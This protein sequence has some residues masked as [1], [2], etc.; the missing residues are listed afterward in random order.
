MTQSWEEIPA[1]GAELA[2]TPALKPLVLS[3]AFLSLPESLLA[4]P[5]PAL[6]A[7]GHLGHPIR[8]AWLG[9]PGCQ[10][11]SGVANQ[12]GQQSGHFLP[13]TGSLLSQP[14]AEGAKGGKHKGVVMATGIHLRKQE[15]MGDASSRR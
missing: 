12:E 10:V 14:R 4:R 15:V 5:G 2:V 1:E 9:A 3:Q 6:F 7:D 8:K 11:V 13:Q